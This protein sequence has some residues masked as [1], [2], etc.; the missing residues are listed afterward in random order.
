MIVSRLTLP[1]KILTS[2]A[3]TAQPHQNIGNKSDR[4]INDTE[5]RA[6]SHKHPPQSCLLILD[7][8]FQTWCI[9]HKFPIFLDKGVQKLGN[10]I[11]KVLPVDSQMNT[12][13]ISIKLNIV[14]FHVNMLTCCNNST[15]Q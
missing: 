6:Y 4:Q 7:M 2:F 15:L 3:L 9:C 11:K 5:K 12:F 8:A 1:A 10:I 14:V 13:Y